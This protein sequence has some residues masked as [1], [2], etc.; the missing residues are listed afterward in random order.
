MNLQQI[1]LSVT[2][3][4]LLTATPTIHAQTTGFALEEIVVTARKREEHLQNTPMSVSAFSAHELTHRQ[5]TATDQLG[6]ITPGLTFDAYAPAS[7]SNASS[8]IFI[9]GIGQADFTAVTDPGVGL[10]V[11]GVYYARSIG[12]TLDFLDLERIE[13][14]RGPQGTLFG[15]NTIGG[16]IVLHTARPQDH[17]AADIRVTTGSDKLRQIKATVNQPVSDT[18]L[19]K[20]SI[21]QRKRDGYVHRVQWPDRQIDAIPAPTDGIDLGN[22]DRLN[23]RTSLLWHATD[24]LN[25]YL[26]ADYSHEDENGAPY[27]SLG[28]NPYQPFVFITNHIENGLA[29][30]GNC[31]LMPPPAP[32]TAG[33]G[34]STNP[35][36]INNSYQRNKH[37]SEG[38]AEVASNLERWGLSLETNWTVLPWLSA[39][40]IT[41]YRDT[42]AYAARDGDGT[43]YRILHTQGRFKHH[44]FSQEL[45][46]DGSYHALNWLLGLY[47]F[48][49]KATDA[50]PVQMPLH[51]IGSIVSGGEV[52]NSNHALFGQVNYHINDQWVLTGGL[53]YSNERKRFAPY[54]WADGFYLQGGAGSTKVR[55]HDCP[56]GSETGCNGIAG[57]LFTQGDRLLPAAEKRRRF[58]H[59]SPAINLS[60]FK[61]DNLMFYGSFSEGFKSGGFDQRYN[62]AFPNGP[63]SFNPETASSYEAGIKSAWLDN[64][65]RLNIATFFTD[66]KAI[67]IIVRE[68]FAPVTHNAGKAEITGFELESTWLPTP[69][70]VVQTGIGYINAKYTHLS[71]GAI[72]AGLVDNAEFNQ[73]PQWSANTSAA[74]TTAIGNKG[75]LDTRL[76][77]SYTGSTFNDAL[78]QPEFYADSYQ[79]LN[80]SV[81]FI[82][83]DS[84]W[85]ITLA[86]KNLGDKLYLV[87]GAGGHAAATGYAEGI[88]SRGRQWSLSAQYHF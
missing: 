16:A 85:Q 68:G 6:E 84:P 21:S 24:N 79:L 29:F 3:I 27:T 74:Y 39:K 23:V 70:W 2:T 22:D 15:R 13:I 67:Q 81:T 54:S 83:A 18:L 66:Y 46:F 51:A 61:N 4:T 57:R 64:T 42:D 72:K 50:S 69:S 75:R 31:P 5:I 71:E 9:R 1:L 77:W 86:G 45:Q 28:L 82:S 26:S 38:T 36:C 12:N 37:Q 56:T 41:A 65:L 33:D 35:R 59:W 76:E 34:T 17:F 88:Y 19:S 11:D 8:Q 87:T 52:N 43:P 63:T 73:T 62:R 40:S 78:N 30:G 10:Y 80:A 60:Y 47:Y 58:D 53:R 7:G 14:L 49:E 20:F 44:Q 32:P 25:F 55:Y 48:Q